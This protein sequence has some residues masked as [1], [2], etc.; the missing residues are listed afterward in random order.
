[1]FFITPAL[2][3]LL[4]GAASAWQEPTFRGGISL[5]KVDAQVLDRSGRIVAGLKAS[6]FQ[7][8]DERQLQKIAYFG[9]ESEPLDLVLL[10]DVSGSMYRH[11]EQLAEAARASLKQLY[12][13]DRVAVALFARSAEIRQ[14]LT[15]DLQAVE[16]EMHDAV[17]TRKLGSGTAI[18]AAV[19]ATA[20]YLQAQK[21]RGRRAVLIVTDN[22]SLNYLVPDEEVIRQL[23][24]ADAVLNG[25]L[26]GK[27]KRPEPP[28]PGRFTN[29]DFTP[30]N[31]F[32][33]AEQTGGE[34]VEAGKI[35]DSFPQMIERIRARYS[36]QYAAPAAAPGAYRHVR[37]EFSPEARGK[38]RGAN[39]RTRAGYYAPE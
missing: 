9:R 8:L 7:I 23:Y 22:V 18:N 2:I 16:E 28:R 4:A 14:P 5:V 27:Q 21:P 39:I 25:I 10:L 31:I 38:L 3:L 15:E 19:V 29:S 33:L 26:I 35:G 34:A 30:S 20:R 6:D 32:K 1:M 24:A 13:G 11:L 17:N 36:I 12:A 37:V